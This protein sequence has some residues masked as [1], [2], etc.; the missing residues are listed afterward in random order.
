[1]S[2][3]F[4]KKDTIKSMKTLIKHLEHLN[5]TYPQPWKEALIG[6]IKYFLKNE[7][8]SKESR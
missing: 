4:S 3:V 2:K 5:N 8:K 6:D 7:T 1:M